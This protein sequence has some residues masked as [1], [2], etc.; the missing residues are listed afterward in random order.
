MHAQYRPI[1]I[2]AAAA[3]V[4]AGC[5]AA[6]EPAEQSLAEQPSAATAATTETTTDAGPDTLICSLE[7]QTGSRFKKKVCR[8]RAQ[9]EE[10]S[11]AARETMKSRDRASGNSNEMTLPTPGG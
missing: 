1:L 2:L 9:I 6:P 8:T 7:P 5:A 3:F 10:Q 11:R 4:F